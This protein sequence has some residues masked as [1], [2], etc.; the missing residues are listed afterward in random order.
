M[1]QI[2][3]FV[4]EVTYTVD[5]T[6]PTAVQYAV[7]K[8]VSNLLVTGGGAGALDSGS[9]GNDV[10]QFTSGKYQVA[11]STANINYSGEGAMDKI[12]TPAVRALLQR[13]IRGSQNTF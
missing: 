13:Y 11:Y 4:Y 5:T 8:G 3:R 6:P 10:Q 12:L 7:I 2:D 1:P 9:G